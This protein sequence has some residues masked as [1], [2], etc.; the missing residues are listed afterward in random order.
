[1]N[2]KGTIRTINK[3]KNDNDIEN[4][5][6]NHIEI[7]DDNDYKESNTNNRNNKSNKSSKSISNSYYSEGS[8]DNN[9]HSNKINKVFLGKKRQ[10]VEDLLINDL[11][12]S[13]KIQKTVE[14]SHSGLFKNSANSMIDS[15]NLSHDKVEF[16]NLSK[17]V[18]DPDDNKILS[19]KKKL[20][21]SSKT[22]IT[23]LCSIF[24]EIN[25]T[26]LKKYKDAHVPSAIKHFLSN[27]YDKET[28]VLSLS[29]RDLNIDH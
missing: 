25:I 20:L 3:N 4:D 29:K 1:M 2:N 16:E 23:N 8:S 13:N 10:F 9:N 5:M 17:N 24:L 14:S 19:L 28:K 21:N 12:D 6:D 22:T 27:N 15:D 26:E 18:F 11:K 7:N